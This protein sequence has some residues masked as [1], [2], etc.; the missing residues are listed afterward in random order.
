VLDAHNIASKVALI[1]SADAFDM[2]AAR[3]LI[4]TLPGLGHVITTE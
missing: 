4:P 2:R 3:A 1:V